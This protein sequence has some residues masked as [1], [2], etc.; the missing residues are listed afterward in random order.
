MPPENHNLAIDWVPT[1][2]VVVDSKKGS[3]HKTPNLSV[4]SRVS[5]VPVSQPTAQLTLGSNWEV[6]CRPTA[7]CSRTA[8]RA[9][10]CC[11]PT[12]QLQDWSDLCQ[13]HRTRNNCASK[14][15]KPTNMIPNTA[16]DSAGDLN[17]AIK[18]GAKTNIQITEKNYSSIR[19]N[20]LSTER[21]ILRLYTVNNCLSRTHPWYVGQHRQ[22]HTHNTLASA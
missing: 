16:P 15:I 22:T 13:Q 7:D 5:F 14:P 4:I 18:Q 1:I 12:D 8:D 19:R 2:V 3:S 9:N 20:N 17:I 10:D 21:K 11:K 6:S